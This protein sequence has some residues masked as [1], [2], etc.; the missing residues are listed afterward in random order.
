MSKKKV[1]SI[2]LTAGLALSVQ[3]AYAQAPKNAPNS[4]AASAFDNKIIKK[5]MLTICITRSL[6]CRNSL[7]RRVLMES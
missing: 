5:L 7:G 4:N 2:L 1:M 3:G 6:Y